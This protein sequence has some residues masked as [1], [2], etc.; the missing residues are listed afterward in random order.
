M[1]PTAAPTVRTGPLG[2]RF[3]SNEKFEAAKNNIDILSERVRTLEG[4]LAIAKITAT[5]SSAHEA[6]VEELRKE[7]RLAQE[8]LKRAQT[9]LVAFNKLTKDKRS[10]LD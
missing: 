8:E 3:V 10:V 9:A 7:L 4:E 2:L 1:S 5:S 6:E